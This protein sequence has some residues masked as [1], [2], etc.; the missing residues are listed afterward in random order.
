VQLEASGSSHLGIWVPAVS[1]G[2]MS[3]PDGGDTRVEC[4]CALM[5]GPGPLLLALQAL[6]LSSCALTMDGGHVVC[7]GLLRKSPPREEAEILCECGQGLA[8]SS[9]WGPREAGMVGP[10]GWKGSG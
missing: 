4:T 2:R 10:C 9:A 5:G 8:W 3:L 6:P 1:M 7:S